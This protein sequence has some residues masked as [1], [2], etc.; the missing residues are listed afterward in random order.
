MSMIVHINGG[1]VKLV[2][3]VYYL[4]PTTP[5]FHHYTHAMLRHVVLT[6]DH[7]IFS[8]FHNFTVH[9]PCAGDLW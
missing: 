6:A 1:W 4:P 3:T 9:G 2:S 8:D 5:H 7:H